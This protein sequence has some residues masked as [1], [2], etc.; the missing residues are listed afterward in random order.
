MRMSRIASV[1]S[2]LL[3]PLGFASALQQSVKAQIKIPV[4][5]KFLDFVPDKD[6]VFSFID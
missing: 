5:M 2:G 1:I 6:I 4:T 3:P